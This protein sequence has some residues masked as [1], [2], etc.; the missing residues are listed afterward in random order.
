MK[1]TRENQKN[2]TRLN[3]R[4]RNLKTNLNSQRAITLIALIVTIVILLILAG[5]SLN[6]VI[7]NNGIISKSKEAVN[8]YEKSVI[9]EKEDMDKLYNMLIGEKEELPE[10]SN[11][12]VTTI[13]LEPQ[14]VELEIGKTLDLKAGLT[15]EPE[16]ATNKDVTWE[17][18]SSTIAKVENGIVTAISKGNATITV[19]S[20]DGSNVS[21]TCDVTV[22]ELPT[23]DTT[24][25]YLPGDDFDKVPGTDLDTGLVIEDG[26]G[27]QY[28]WVEVPQTA[29]VYRTAGLNITGF[30]DADYTKI[31]NDLKTYT[32]AYRTPA[33]DWDKNSTSNY[34]DTY[35]TYANT[36]LSKTEYDTLK[37][38]MLKSVYK[39]GGFYVGRYET[40]VVDSNLQMPVIKQNAY[41]IVA[42][43]SIADCQQIAEN[44]TANYQGYVS[45]L[46][47]GVQWDLILKYLESKGTS[48]NLLKV[49]STSWGNYI[50]SSYIITNENSKYTVD[51]LN[52]KKTP[53]NSPK[54]SGDAVMLTTGASD[55]F[56]KQNI[57]D[58]AGNAG[59]ATL[60]YSGSINS[61]CI[62][63]GEWFDVN[64]ADGISDTV[65]NARYANTGG[66]FVGVRVVLYKDE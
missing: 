7:G 61:P 10:D 9:K 42:K 50:S 57:Y 32:S 22:T 39:N 33:Y 35:S 11:I 31:E 21:A 8:E 26:T 62:G 30:T 29:D 19:S 52:W 60:E 17:S 13:K 59:E 6:L 51:G 34:S 63:R 14:K 12:K 64:F 27:N 16:D 65:A 2:N 56:A 1:R 5:V 20:T 28:V 24:K 23:T 37:K 45:S 49:N 4:S 53:T 58:L 66:G 47:F 3:T 55:K 18:N 15:I 36:G 38:K 54:N 40:G 48:Q 44:F 43:I 46:M 41:P 25:P